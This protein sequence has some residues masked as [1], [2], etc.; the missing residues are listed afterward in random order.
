MAAIRDAV[1]TFATIVLAGCSTPIAVTDHWPEPAALPEGQGM[2][3]GSIEM[4]MPSGVT[5]PARKEMVDEF[6]QRQLTATLR[7]YVDSD[8]PTLGTGREYV[9]D[10][11]VV[12]LGFDEEKR[13][14]LCAPVGTYEIVELAADHPG[15]FG[16]DEGSKLLR[17]ATFAIH[18]GMT[19]YV[20][21]LVV[22]VGFRPEP[23]VKW[24]WAAWI[25]AHSQA[26]DGPERWLDMGLSVVDAKEA[27]LKAL[28]GE[29]S[30]APAGVETILMKCWGGRVQ[31]E[32]PKPTPMPELPPPRR[33]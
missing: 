30:R 19:S 4:T 12:A 1:V 20:G 29:P 11:Y 9:G 13:F 10:P 26:H 7:R 18:A 8:G 28:V 22:A 2:S 17:V 25:A 14:V 24:E 15:L 3:F 6:R 5:D 27:T 16:E 32:Q 31:F 33:K 23:Q 21:K